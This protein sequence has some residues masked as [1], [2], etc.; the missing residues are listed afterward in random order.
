MS[1]TEKCKR[2]NLRTTT[3]KNA[4]MISHGRPFGVFQIILLVSVYRSSSSLFQLRRKKYSHN[5]FTTPRMNVSAR[6]LSACVILRIVNSLEDIEFGRCI[7]S[8]NPVLFMQ[9]VHR[10]PNRIKL[11]IWG[12]MSESDLRSRLA[13]AQ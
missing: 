13:A 6:E 4:N 1:R 10:G 5:Y 8:Q 7:S 2:S 11:Q 12:L 3:I 9:F